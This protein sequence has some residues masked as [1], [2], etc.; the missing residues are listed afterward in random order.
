[1]EEMRAKRDKR[2]FMAVIGLV[3]SNIRRRDHPG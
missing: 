3:E 2:D 1:M